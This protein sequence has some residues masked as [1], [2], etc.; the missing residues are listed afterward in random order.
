MA[1]SKDLM[2]RLHEA[3][4]TEM[5]KMLDEGVTAKDEE[6]NIVKLSPSPSTMNVIRQFLKDNNIEAD[7]A[8][9]K[10]LQSVVAKLPFEGEDNVHQFPSVSH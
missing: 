6:G 3:L 10:P 5:S 1:A 8:K 7:L 4:A 9:S 2:S